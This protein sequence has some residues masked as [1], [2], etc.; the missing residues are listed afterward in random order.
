MDQHRVPLVEGLLGHLGAH[1]RSFHVPGHQGGRRVEGKLGRLMGDPFKAD[2]TELPGLDNL[3]A[4]RG[5]IREAQELAAELFQARETFFLVNGTTGGLLAMLCGVC[6]PGDQVIIPRQSHQAVYAGIIAS[7]AVPCY[8]PQERWAGG[9]AWSNVSSRQVK[10][11]LEQN[12]GAR[13]LL[14]AN[15]SYLGVCPDL[16]E[17]RRLTAQGGVLLLVDE[18]HGGHLSL[19]PGFP[20]GASQVGADLWVQSTHKT[21]GSLT[22]SSML[23]RGSDKVDRSRLVEM[24]NLYQTTSPS[25]LLLASLDAARG[26]LAREGRGLLE[27]VRSLAEK[28]R[29]S[30]V[31]LGFNLLPSREG[32]FCL[33]ITRLAAF[34]PGPGWRGKKLA[35]RLREEYLVQLELFSDSYLLF[36]LTLGHREEDVDYLIQALEEII[37]RPGSGVDGTES[38]GEV[39]PYAGIPPRRLIPRDAVNCP[40]EV[41]PLE[42]AAGRVAAGMVNLF[43]PGVPLLVPGELVVPEMLQYISWKNAQGELSLPS[44]AGIKPGL[45]VVK[46]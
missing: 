21:L 37:R 45:K 36:V 1:Y 32:E 8:L 4:P 22:Q 28:L 24:L 29:E 17:I 27:G 41:V 25:Y 39:A 31:A 18:A 26:K 40:G 35:L 38:K 12:P 30:L 13:A 42:E 16:G 11:A 23:H 43:P 46:E 14:V 9:E 15:P 19:H 3:Q 6:R 7:G 10:E 2:L 34:M 44:I 33:D 20:P 5:I